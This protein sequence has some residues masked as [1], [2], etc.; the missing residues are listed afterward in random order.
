[1]GSSFIGG[2]VSPV[3]HHAAKSTSTLNQSSKKVTSPGSDVT[4]L[5]IGGD[6]FDK[7]QPS[8]RRVDGLAKVITVD[9]HSDSSDVYDPSNKFRTSNS[10][11]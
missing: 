11:S 1:M 8:A 5:F 4:S 10:H 3:G 2:S 6:A 9:L 7:S